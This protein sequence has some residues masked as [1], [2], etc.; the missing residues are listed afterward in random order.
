MIA[1][2]DAVDTISNNLS[3]V[4]T[5]GYKKETVEFKSLLYSKLQTKTTDNEGNPKPVIGQVGAG[6]RTASITSRYTQGPLN[7]TGNTFDFAL[8]GEG[9]FQVQMPDGSVAYT[10]SGAFNMSI[11]NEGLTLCT[12]EGYPILDAGNQ[13]IVF[14]LDKESNQFFVDEE[15]YFYYNEIIE[16]PVEPETGEEAEGAVAEPKTKKI[17]QQVKL[18]VRFGIVQFNNPTGLFK[19]SNSLLQA[20]ESSGEPM[21][22]TGDTLLKSTKVHSGYLEGSNVA[23]VDEMVNLIIAQRAYEMNSKVITASDQMLQQANNLRG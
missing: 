18:D 12:A 17:T 20:T 5:T 6:V 3:N 14:G 7:A 22:E 15:G 2:Q 21:P 8:E 1:Q 9:F 13:P 16:V 4:N 19:L 23:T 11:G 10:R